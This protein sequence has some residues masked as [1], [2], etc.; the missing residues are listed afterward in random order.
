MQ[1]ARAFMRMSRWHGRCY[2]ASRGGNSVHEQILRN[3]KRSSK[4]RFDSKVIRPN[5]RWV[6]SSETDVSRTW[7]RARERL[8]APA[9]SLQPRVIRIK[10]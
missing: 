4:P 2:V 5:G 9:L 8:K 6:P 10:L 7:A 3:R 1:N